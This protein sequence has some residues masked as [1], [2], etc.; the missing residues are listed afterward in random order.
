MEFDN[1]DEMIDT[2]NDKVLENVKNLMTEVRADKVG[3]DHR[4]GW[5]YVNKEYIAVHG[6]ASSLDYY[7]G[8]EYIDPDHT[9]TCGDFKFYSAESDRVRECI[10][11]YYKEV[12]V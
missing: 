8:F 11:T 12:E 6:G 4:A 5:V 2:V 9:F 7:G 3:L 10:E 1:I